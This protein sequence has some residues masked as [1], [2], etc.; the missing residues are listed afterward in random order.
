MFDVVVREAVHDPAARGALT[1]FFAGRVANA[2]PIVERSVE[3]GEIPAEDE[4]AEVIRQLGGRRITRRLYITGDPIGVADADR[5][6]A[7]TAA[8]GAGRARC[9]P[10]GGPARPARAGE[11]V[12]ARR[13]GRRQ[14]REAARTCRAGSRKSSSVSGPR[15][16][17]GHQRA[18]ALQQARNRRSSSSS[19]S[20]TCRTS[21]GCPKWS[22]VYCDRLEAA[23]R[24]ACGP[25]RPATA[26]SARG[27]SA[28]AARSRG[29]CCDGRTP[30]PMTTTL[31]RRWSVRPAA[32][33][34]RPAA[35]AAD[36]TRSTARNTSRV[37]DRP[38]ALQDREQP[39]QAHAG[40]DA[41]SGRAARGGRRRA[42]GSAS[43][44][45]STPR[46]TAGRWSACPAAAR[47]RSTRRS[48]SPG[49]TGRSGRWTTSSP[50]RVS[51][52]GTPSSSQVSQ[53]AGV[54]ADLS[55]PPN[56]VTCSRSGA[57]PEA[58]AEQLVAPAQALRR[59]GSRR[60]TRSRASRTR[61][62]GCRRRPRRGRWCAGSAARLTRRRPSGCG[63]PAGTG[64]SGCMPEVVNSTGS[65]GGGTS[66]LP[67]NRA[68][69]RARGRS[70]GRC[71]RS[72]RRSW[73]CAFRVGSD[74]KGAPR[75]QQR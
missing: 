35:R 58:V 60:A 45:G 17:P 10:G 14:D 48:P 52:T 22:S 74:R 40:V 8:A 19:T 9:A 42:G 49:R 5:A 54:R 6:A 75:A 4:A 59:P 24:R 32:A 1:G 34:A 44:R 55:S 63:R 13:A 68:G 2:A 66:E 36:G 20:R 51:S 57:D 69:G 53:G 29:R 56:T 71:G 61:S 43:S 70:R 50:R 73:R 65:P 3:R 41:A 30:S 64:V 7:V 26:W 47:R 31:E 39:L 27:G 11:L 28:G 21:V 46:P 38:L 18:A 72:G 37:E 25:G 67:G 15:D 62:G 16:E 33:T 12:P 23:G